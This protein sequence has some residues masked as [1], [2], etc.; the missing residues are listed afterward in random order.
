MLNVPREPIPN[1]SRSA[2][3]FRVKQF[4][5][6]Q[7]IGIHL[8]MYSGKNSLLYLA[9]RHLLDEKMVVHGFENKILDLDSIK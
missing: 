7:Y 5:L 4:S 3:K 6:I 9:L 1:S 2:A 8:V